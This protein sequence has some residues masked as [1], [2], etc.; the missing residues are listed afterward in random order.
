[1]PVVFKIKIYLKNT[2]HKEITHTMWMKSRKSSL[3]GS[4]YL[5][6]IMVLAY[7]LI[8]SNN[9]SYFIDYF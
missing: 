6:L 7:I 3:S 1:M 2:W 8:D 4:Q 9:P 5:L